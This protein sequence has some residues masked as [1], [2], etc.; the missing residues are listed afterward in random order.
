MIHHKA[1]GFYWFGCICFCMLLVASCQRVFAANNNVYDMPSHQ[2]GSDATLLDSTIT[3]TTT[4]NPN[5]NNNNSI[6]AMD[7]IVST[8][9][10]ITTT[11][12]FIYKRS[13]SSIKFELDTVEFTYLNI[14]VLMASHL[15]KLAWPD[16][17]STAHTRINRNGI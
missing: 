3:A 11:E 2:Y 15:G 6:D 1:L 10:E 13:T 4:T 7:E 8:F 9:D 12:R 16:T 5:N 17:H 14:G